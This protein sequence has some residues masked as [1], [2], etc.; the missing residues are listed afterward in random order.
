M[1][2]FPLNL[3]GW[4]FF[5]SITTASYEYAYSYSYERPP[6]PASL[7][8]MTYNVHA[9]RDCSHV[10]N[11]QRVV[12]AVQAVQ[13]DICCLN[14]VLHPFVAPKGSDGLS[15]YEDVKDGKGRGLVLP[16]DHLPSKVEDSFLYRL[17]KDTGLQ[18]LEYGA[19][20]PVDSSFGRVPFGNA[21]LSRYAIKSYTHVPLEVDEGDIDLGFQKRDIVDPRQ[22]I[23][24]TVDVDGKCVGLISTH[25]DQKSEELRGKQ[26]MKVVKAANNILS[27]ECPTIICGDFNSF[28]RSDMDEATWRDLCEL[29]ESRTWGRPNEVSLVLKALEDDGYA[30]T[31]AFSGDQYPKPTCWTDT[32]VMRIDHMLVKSPQVKSGKQKSHYD[33]KALTHQRVEVDG[34]DHFPVFVSFDFEII[35]E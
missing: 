22:A 26:T 1:P 23:V 27:S 4:A 30:D 11:F 16:R 32:P 13:P 12:E 21:I 5:F 7:R 19:A 28:R 31:F 29:Y 3:G 17:A 20:D 18:Y 15:Y 35:T 25:L 24:A 33:I 34:S 8:V 9:W 6:C 14:E 10:D 2:L